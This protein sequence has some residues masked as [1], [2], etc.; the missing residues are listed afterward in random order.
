MTYE[1]AKQA[2]DNLRFGAYRDSKQI[3][4][5]SPH[6]V[7]IS[8]INSN[9]CVD[10]YIYT[11]SSWELCRKHWYSKKEWI[12][13]DDGL[14][15]D[16]TTGIVSPREIQSTKS[17]VV[18]SDHED[19]DFWNEFSTYIKAANEAKRYKHENIVEEVFL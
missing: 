10:I 2:A 18:T 17:F 3:D 5:K 12:R 4:Y 16:I 6:H 15:I 8:D 11:N 7:C 13:K 1:F 14:T 9:T 19:I